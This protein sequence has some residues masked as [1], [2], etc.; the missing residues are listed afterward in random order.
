MVVTHNK[1]NE[2]KNK[3]REKEGSGKK[4]ETGKRKWRESVNKESRRREI[5]EMY[6]NGTEMILV[7]R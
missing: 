7:E 6:E 5:A 4:G 3:R 1:M 2:R